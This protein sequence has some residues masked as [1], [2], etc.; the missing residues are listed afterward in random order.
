MTLNEDLVDQVDRVARQLKTTRSAFA[1]IALQEA[2]EKHA[3]AQKERVHWAGYEK[4]PVSADEFSVWEAEVF[5][6]KWC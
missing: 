4:H 5:L 2:L 1:R 6:P 3:I